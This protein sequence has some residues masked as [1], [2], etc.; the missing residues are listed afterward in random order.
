MTD[1]L[2]ALALYLIVVGLML[3]GLSLSVAHGHSWYDPDCC[4][5]NDCAPIAKERVQFV[6]GGYL[7]DGKHFIEA[8]STRVRGSQDD[9][10]HA[11]F[12]PADRLWCFYI[13]ASGV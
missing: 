7:I 8:T 5:D 13:P 2:K 12:W 1:E 9:Q 4:G 6:N 11:C 10:F 3:I